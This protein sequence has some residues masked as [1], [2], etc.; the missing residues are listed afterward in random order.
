MV[1]SKMVPYPVA[2]MDIGEPVDVPGGDIGAE[3]ELFWL[4]NMVS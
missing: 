2:V 4:A 3:V 1:P